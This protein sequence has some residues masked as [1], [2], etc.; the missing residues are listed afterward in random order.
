[1]ASRQ[2]LAHVEH[3]DTAAAVGS[4]ARCLGT[5]CGPLQYDDGLHPLAYHSS[6]YAPAERNYGGGEKEL[7]A[8]YQVCVKWCCYIDGVPTMI[9]TDHEPWVNIWT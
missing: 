5:T 7:L 9:Y 8:I 2:W 1:M 4:D 6:K 3:S